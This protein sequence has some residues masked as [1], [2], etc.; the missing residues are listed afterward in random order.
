[1]NFRRIF[2]LIVLFSTV[3]SAFAGNSRPVSKR[4]CARTLAQNERSQRDD[5][6]DGAAYDES[7]NDNSVGAAYFDHD[8][9]ERNSPGND[10][11]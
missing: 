7:M 8:E 3:P 9:N 2:C 11:H 10:L 4:T 5:R 6:S 1:M